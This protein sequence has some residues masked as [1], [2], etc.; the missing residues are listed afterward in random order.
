MWKLW[1]EEQFNWLLAHPPRKGHRLW[2]WQALQDKCLDSKWSFQTTTPK[3]AGP[4]GN[5]TK[6]IV[7]IN[8][9]LLRLA[10]PPKASGEP[11]INTFTCD[12][13]TSNGNE[14]YEPPSNQGKAYTDTDSD[15]KTEIITDIT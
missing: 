15:G 10:H 12:A 13:L 9:D 14:L 11:F 5:E 6:D 3:V 4:G 2:R 7:S 8:T 1:E